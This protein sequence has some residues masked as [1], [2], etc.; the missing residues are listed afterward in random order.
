MVE[1]ITD[2]ELDDMEA[3]AMAATQGPWRAFVEGR[4]HLSG[5]SFIRTGDDAAPDMYVS[6]V[7]PDRSGEVPAPVA[8]L[9]FIASARQ[10][11]PR[12]VTELRR[13]RQLPGP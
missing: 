8:D 6:V 9:D 7:S 4:D 3:R 2:A 1:G 5:D 13:L 12:L 11:L 10:D